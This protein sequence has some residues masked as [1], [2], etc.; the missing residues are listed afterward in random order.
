MF[1]P[2][3]RLGS[4]PPFEATIEHEIAMLAAEDVDL[5]IALMRSSS[6]GVLGEVMVIAS[7]KEIKAKT[8][9]LFPIHYYTPDKSLVADT[10]RSYRTR[11][12]YDDALFESCQLVGECRKWA[13]DR[14]RGYWAGARPKSY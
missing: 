4:V 3:E 2:E 11:Q 7:F 6:A 14:A 1:F 8:A 12:L 13:H 5:V 9:V 10:V